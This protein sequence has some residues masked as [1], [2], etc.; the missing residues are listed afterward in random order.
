VAGAGAS[1]VAPHASCRPASVA[2]CPV[3]ATVRLKESRARKGGE[4][5]PEGPPEGQPIS[6]VACRFSAVVSPRRCI[7]SFPDPRPSN[8]QPV[9][10]APALSAKISV[11]GQAIVAA[12]PAARRVAAK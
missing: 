5:H 12:R 6:C 1:W 9:R 4:P 2:P 3:R 11:R 10:M 8:P 7:H